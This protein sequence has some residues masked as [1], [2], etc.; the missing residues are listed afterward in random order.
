MEHTILLGN[1]LQL[2]GNILYCCGTYYIIVLCTIL[3]MSTAGSD[4]RMDVTGYTFDLERQV[5]TLSRRNF[6]ETMYLLFEVDSAGPMTVGT[7]GTLAALASSI[8]RSVGKR[9]LSRRCYMTVW[10]A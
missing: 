9:G 5:V 10:G 7:M 1:I 2:L 6:L 4:R 3:L 8:Q